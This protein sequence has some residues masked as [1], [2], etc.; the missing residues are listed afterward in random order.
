MWYRDEMPIH[1][2]VADIRDLKYRKEFDVVVSIGLLEHFP[3]SHK[4]ECLEMHRRFLKPG[5]TVVMT[6]PRN[7]F[8]SRVFYHFMA[9]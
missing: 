2:E 5:G 8:K 4:A 3:D 6:T 1:F 9:D 7:Q